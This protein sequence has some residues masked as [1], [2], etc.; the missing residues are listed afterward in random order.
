MS[1]VSNSRLGYVQSDMFLISVAYSLIY[2]S[3]FLIPHM[4]SIE[5]P[6][7]I[8]M[9][10]FTFRMMC[11]H[12][13]KVHKYLWLMRKCRSCVAWHV[14]VCVLAQS[15]QKRGSSQNKLVHLVLIL[16]RC[17]AQSRPHLQR[18]SPEPNWAPDH[19]TGQPPPRS[20]PLPGLSWP[21]YTIHKHAA[22]NLFRSALPR[23][24]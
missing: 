22:T 19:S 7:I 15:I 2:G 3:T 8:N 11:S 1:L 5:E 13:F 4:H 17:M 9:S 20:W 16:F 18:K 12:I 23:K 21:D 14:Q 24:H 6:A 10:E